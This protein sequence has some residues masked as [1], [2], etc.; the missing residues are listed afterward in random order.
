MTSPILTRRT[1]LGAA[2][3]VAAGATSAADADA[4]A[5]RW[6]AK[7]PEGF[8][9]LS[10]PGKVVKVSRP[11]SLQRNGAYPKADAAEA[12]VTAAMTTLT[13]KASL[14]EAFAC[15]V[16]PSDVVVIKVNGIAGRKSRKMGTNVEVIAPIARAIVDL[17]VPP[18]KVTVLEQFRDFLMATR[19]IQAREGLVGAPEM[20][21]G[22]RYALHSNKDAVMD[23]ILVG[24]VPTQF[25]TTFTSSTVVINVTQ[26]KDHSICG[27]TG[28]LKN[29]THGCCLNPHDFHQHKATP[30]IAHLYAQ[31]VVRSRVAVHISDAFQV[32]YD[33]GPIDVNPNKRVRHEAV[34]A[35]TDPVALDTIGWEVIE[36][37]RKKHGMPTLAEA[38]REPTYIRIAEQL[39]LG[40]ADR[41]SITLREVGA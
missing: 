17:G 31:E 36:S 12:M 20:P 28:A 16:H 25:C 14:R 22:I 19:C 37:F 24:G 18:E 9:R 41:A 15:F 26:M 38:K 3:A 1:L 30:Q 8:S 10:I 27:F 29:I 34:Y 21:Q 32:I 6:I 23:E 13:G 35:S 11:D 33:E 40:V 5:K 7:A 4:A 39:G 2:A